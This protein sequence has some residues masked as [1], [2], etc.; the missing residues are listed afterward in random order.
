MNGSS[1]GRY[2]SEWNRRIGRCFLDMPKPVLHFTE[3]DGLRCFSIQSPILIVSNTKRKHH[4]MFPRL[5]I[6]EYLPLATF[7][8]LLCN[9]AAFDSSCL[10]V[11]QTSNAD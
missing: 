3:W 8:H 2:G 10:L 4:M 1:R 11:H 9:A 7:L 5:F 6:L